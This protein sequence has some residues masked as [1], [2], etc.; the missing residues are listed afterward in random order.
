MPKNYYSGALLYNPHIKQGAVYDGSNHVGEM[1][2]FFTKCSPIIFM[3]IN[4]VK[5][6]NK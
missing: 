6:I 3:V 1:V 2:R 5:Y 4:D